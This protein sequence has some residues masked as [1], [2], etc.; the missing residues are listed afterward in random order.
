MLFNS[1][2]FLI[3]LPIVVVLYYL[4][5]H[6]V[7]WIMLLIASYTFYM[8]W[9]A[10][11]ALIIAGSTV[12]DWA[13]ALW[14][15]KQ[16]TRRTRLPLLMVSLIMNLGLLCTFKYADFAIDSINYLSGSDWPQLGWILPVGISFYTF[17]TLSYTLD[18]YLGNVKAERHLGQFALF[19]IYFPQLVAGPIERYA[20]LAPQLKTRHT[21]Q[22]Q[23][24]AR[25]F[26]FVLLGLAVK[27][28]VADR[29]AGYV[30]SVYS[31]PSAWNGLDLL[32][33]L[34]LYAF[35]I[36]CD[37]Y[38]YSMVAI[39]SAMFV[40]VSL[41]ENF[42]TPYLATTIAEFWQR[43]HRSLSQWF[44]DYVFIPLGGSRVNFF[45]LAFNIMVVFGLSGLWHGANWT[46]I[47]W[48]VGWGLAYI[49]EKGIGRFW[50][51][52]KPRPYSLM[53]L[54]NAAKIFVI[55]S[56]AWIAFRS[57][58]L[59]TMKLVAKG[60]TQWPTDCAHLEVDLVTWIALGVF[61]LSDL[62]LYN[63][64]FDELCERWPW[65]VRWSVYGLLTYAIIVFASQQEFAFIYF[66][67]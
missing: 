9:K 6:K 13:L 18:V 23:N 35:Q 1:T 49:I 5:P 41:M 34:V 38:G 31:D 58:N 54:L 39:G 61:I 66:Q 3:F 2:D 30:D 63:R 56:L 19:V 52:P 17:Q 51:L 40:G 50:K 57:S 25:G 8:F 32:T 55:A 60:L 59:D 67:F 21:I 43:W 47:A 29:L 26:R 37:F 53:H 15:D 28:V 42:K 48:G 20:D 64:R 11:F 33:G 27:M 45:R 46:F 62:L 4:L 7:R 22:Y 24:F 10:E 36:Y 65:P 12:V 16:P 14:M 44:R